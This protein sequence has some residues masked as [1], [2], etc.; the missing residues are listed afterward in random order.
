MMGI[1]FI[2][3]ADGPS[4]ALG[5][6]S[7]GKVIVGYSGGQA[8]VWDAPHGMRNLQ[9]VLLLE[10]G[11]DFSG[12]TLSTANAVSPDATEVVGQGTDFLGNTQAFA[13][14]INS[15]TYRFV[16]GDNYQTFHTSHLG[17]HGTSVNFLGGIA[18]GARHFPDGNGH[19]LRGDQHP[20]R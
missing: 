20:T 3:G 16:S 11:V 10:Y 4:S 13:A 5:V 18:G 9:S 19:H 6:S 15:R 17:G 1:G 12:W 8:F 2:A 14:Q 7:D